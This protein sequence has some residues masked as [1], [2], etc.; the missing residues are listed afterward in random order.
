MFHLVGAC[1]GGRWP[2]SRWSAVFNRRISVGHSVQ[3]LQRLCQRL[4]QLQGRVKCPRLE[5]FTVGEETF[6]LP[7]TTISRP[8]EPADRKELEYL[9]GF[10]DGD[11]AVSVDPQG[12]T[13]LHVDQNVD[14]AGVLLRYRCSFGGGIFRSKNATGRRK[15]CLKWQVTGDTCRQA[16]GILRSVA[17]MKRAQLEIVAGGPVPLQDAGVVRERLSELRKSSFSPQQINCSWPYF[18]GFFDA[19]GGMCVAPHTVSLRLSLVQKN[20]FAP[21]RL[22]DF[23]RQQQLCWRLRPA[24]VAMDLTCTDLATCR[25]SLK[26]MLQNG[27]LVKKDQAE[28]ALTLT[29]SN[30]VHVREVLSSLK[31]YQNRYRRLDE[32]G[33]DRSKQIHKLA[34]RLHSTSLPQTKFHLEEELQAL[35]QEHVRQNLICKA[36]ALRA[37]IRK[38]LRE[39]AII[40]PHNATG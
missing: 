8:T 39:G 38:L 31:G 5:S 15:A 27:L 37:D 35:R 19:D 2:C 22:L 4:E 33:M 20:P 34:I 30:H 40:L 32:A 29:A 23:L 17:S 13:S 3:R 18:T 21:S 1:V 11:G 24:G 16:A 26:M 25:Q 14:S 12:R 9:V 28:L 36:K 7:L 6:Q 10:F